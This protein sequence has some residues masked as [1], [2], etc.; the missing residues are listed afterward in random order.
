M[1]YFISDTHFNHT[2]IIKYCNRPFK[3]IN[4]MNKTIIKNWNELVT[5]D[6]ISK[7]FR[8][9]GENLIIGNSKE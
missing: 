4:E 6:D 3:D 9:E 1:I 5:N 7:L 2:N 8:V